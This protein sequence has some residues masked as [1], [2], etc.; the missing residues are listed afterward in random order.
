MQTLKRE[1]ILLRKNPLQWIVPLLFFLL[2]GLIFPLSISPNLQ[3]L[4]SMG[5]GVIWVSMLLALLLSQTQLYQRDYESGVLDQ[6]LIQ[7]S[8]LS[9]TLS[10][11]FFVHWLMFILPMILLTPLLSLMYNL[12]FFAIMILLSSLLL[13]TPILCI[14]GMIV[15]ALCVG[16]RKDGLLLAIILL[17]LYIPTLIFGTTVVGAASLGQPVLFQLELLGALLI[18]ALTV[19]SGIAAFAL[20]IGIM[21]S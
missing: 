15:S 5:A 16:V 14:Q 11:K 17:P 20:R 9:S 1:F 2:T 21:Y 13:G 7:S 19:G 6:W 4:Q 12:S 8:S 18:L 10:K 3:M